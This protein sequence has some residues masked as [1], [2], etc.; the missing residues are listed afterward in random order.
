M[1]RGRR[2]VLGVVLGVG[3]GVVFAGGVQAVLVPVYGITNN[4]PVD[5]AVGEDQLLI[6]V[7]NGGP[8]VAFTFYNIGA[9]MCTITDIYFDDGTLL[10][11]TG[12]IDADDGTGG[13]PF[14]DFTQHATPANLPGGGMMPDPFVTSVGFSADADSPP[15]AWG[16]SPGQSLGIEFS[17]TSGDVTQVIQELLD[18]TLRIGLHVQNFDGCGSESFVNVPEPATVAL[19][20]LGALLL[21]RRRA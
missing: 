15:S 11:L 12:L 7:T 8:G 6:D 17:L 5:V 14:V 1:G 4:N 16:V 10:A 21:R 20:G 18:K 3:I 2:V 19:L 13:D 9:T